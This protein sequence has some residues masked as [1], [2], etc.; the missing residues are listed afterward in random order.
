MV[1]ILSISN[2]LHCKNNNFLPKTVKS[3][4]GFWMKKTAKVVRDSE[5]N[6]LL[7]CMN[8]LLQFVKLWYSRLLSH[9]SNKKKLC[10]TCSVAVV[11]K[12]DDV[13]HFKC[14]LKLLVPLSKSGRF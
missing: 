5:K 13:S 11:D 1:R 12:R 9:H 6:F 2:H 3:V 4:I 14:I 10:Y 7:I 8:G